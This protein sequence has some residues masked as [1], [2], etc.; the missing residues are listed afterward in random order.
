MRSSDITK[1]RFIADL[2]DG[3]YTMCLLVNPTRA[4]NLSWTVSHV[5]ADQIG[6]HVVLALCLKHS[7]A[8]TLNKAQ[9]TNQIGTKKGA[10]KRPFVKSIVITLGVISLF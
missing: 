6:P 5:F 4:A 9:E 7:H 3:T 1:G 8:I 2:Q 10:I